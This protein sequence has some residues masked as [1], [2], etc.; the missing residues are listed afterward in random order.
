[1]GGFGCACGWVVGG[2]VGKEQWVVG[3]SEGLGEG[4]G[5]VGRSLWWWWLGVVFVVWWWWWWW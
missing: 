2:G 4:C 3:R 1:M 5:R